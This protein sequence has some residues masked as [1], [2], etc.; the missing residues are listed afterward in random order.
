MSLER[1][2]DEQYKSRM[3][4]VEQYCKNKSGERRNGFWDHF[5]GP[6]NPE[7]N[8][9]FLI[10]F[11]DAVK[12]E[13]MYPSLLAG[14]FHTENDIDNYAKL[15]DPKVLLSGGYVKAL[16]CYYK[17]TSEPSHMQDKDICLGAVHSYKGFSVEIYIGTM[18]ESKVSL[19]PRT[20]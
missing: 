1:F 15:I 13:G 2:E 19:P 16:C 17:H 9:W 14:P 12:Y 7:G 18:Y 6:S 5:G 11:N 10:P 8:R 3:R 20:L 4:R